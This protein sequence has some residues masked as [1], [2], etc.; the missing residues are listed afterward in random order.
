M[1]APQHDSKKQQ[2]STVPPAAPYTSKF[3]D[4]G[5]LKLHYL[6]Y[7]TEGRPPMVC[8]HGGGAN[9][10]WFDF[11]ARGFTDKYHVRALDLRGHGESEHVVPPAYFYKDYASDLNKAVEKLDLR[12][13]VLMGHSMGGA[14]SLLYAATYPG[15]M[16][17]LIIIDSTVNL[18]PERIAELRGVGSRPARSYATQ[19]ELISRY[20]LRP[21]ASQAAPE[22]VR[23]VASSSGRQAADGSWGHKFDRDVYATRETFDGRPNWDRIKVPA[24]LVKGDCSNRISPEVYADVKARCPQAE[25]AEVSKSDHHVTLDNPSEFIEKVRLYLQK[26][27]NESSSVK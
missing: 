3:V 10:H 18:S 26:A 15:R 16:K 1:S 12:D 24:L 11:V 20:R 19:E 8:I 13:F 2:S 7:G 14:V 25:L 17:T 5:D 4:T 27:V 23:H 21:G 22:V 9:G 6:D